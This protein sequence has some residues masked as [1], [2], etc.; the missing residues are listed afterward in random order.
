MIALRDIKLVTILN[1]VQTFSPHSFDQGHSLK[2]I[3]VNPK[4]APVSLTMTQEA[5]AIAS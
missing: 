4:S 2:S 1:T 3:A 5:K